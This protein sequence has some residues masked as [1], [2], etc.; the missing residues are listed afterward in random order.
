MNGVDRVFVSALNTIKRL[1]SHPSAPKPPLEDRLL[2]YA[3]FKQ[4]MEGDVP[5]SLLAQLDAPTPSMRAGSTRRSVASS[6]RRGAGGG[7]GG[8]EAGVEE[9]ADDDGSRDKI[10]AWAAQRGTTRQ[11]A[12]RLYITTLLR[13]MRLYGS[14]TANARALIDE[15]EF[16]WQQVRASEGHEGDDEDDGEELGASPVRTRASSPRDGGAT[17]TTGHPPGDEEDEEE[18]GFAPPNVYRTAPPSPARRPNTTGPAVPMTLTHIDEVAGDGAPGDSDG[19]WRARLELSLQHLRAELAGLRESLVSGD[20][21]P[22]IRSGYATAGGR[23][24]HLSGR[25]AASGHRHGHGSR[26]YS[27]TDALAATLSPGANGL[28]LRHRSY[29]ADGR[30]GEHGHGH[31]GHDGSGHHGGGGRWLWS[32]SDF[33]SPRAYHSLL[34]S[35]FRRLTVVLRISVAVVVYDALALAAVWYVLWLRDDPRAQILSHLAGQALKWTA[36]KLK[37]KVRRGTRTIAERR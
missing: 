12:K 37:L 35:L 7:G 2:L 22:T 31:G 1:P 30:P 27:L 3:L 36:Y 16:V 8:G 25:G 13:S 24:S 4:S 26:S 21:D 11:E 34:T 23:H 20:F 6:V 33:S 28:G 5:D 14:Q 19:R 32:L 18:L 17:R 29:R 15:L 9:D 10:A